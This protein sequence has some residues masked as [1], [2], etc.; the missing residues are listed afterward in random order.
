MFDKLI[1]SNYTSFTNSNEREIVCSEDIEFCEW[2]V[3]DTSLSHDPYILLM[4]DSILL[5]QRY[6]S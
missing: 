3:F 1:N 4:I 6:P 2:G 5:H